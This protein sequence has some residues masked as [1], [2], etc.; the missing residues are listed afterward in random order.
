[1]TSRKKIKSKR[2]KKKAA[3]RSLRAGKP[4]TIKTRKRPRFN[5]EFDAIR[6]I[7]DL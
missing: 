1:M 7:L 6:G 5:P 4:N 3:T 2:Q